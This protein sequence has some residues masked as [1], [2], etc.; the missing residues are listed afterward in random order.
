MD[1]PLVWTWTTMPIQ[2]FH[3]FTWGVKAWHAAHMNILP[4]PELSEWTFND[5]HSNCKHFEPSF[6]RISQVLI[7]IRLFEDE[8][9]NKD[10]CQ[11]RIFGGTNLCNKLPIQV[12]LLRTLTGVQ[13]DTR[14]K[15]LAA[16][17]TAKYL[18]WAG[19]G[20]IEGCNRRKCALVTCSVKLSHIGEVS[21]VCN[22][23]QIGRDCKDCKCKDLKLKWRRQRI[24]L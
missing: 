12:I 1:Y 24:R 5:F 19:I 11:L 22:W 21:E 3:A 18:T 7:E 15:A 14:H 23:I 2:F 17:S 8:L 6:V 9:Q 16:L 13:G 20:L 10:F 4:L